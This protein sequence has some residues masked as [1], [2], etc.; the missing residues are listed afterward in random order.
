M[1]LANTSSRMCCH[2]WQT[3]IV[4]S[5]LFHKLAPASDLHR[6]ITARPLEGAITLATL[7]PIK[8][9]D[10]AILFGDGETPEVFTEPCGIVGRSRNFTVNT[11]SDDL[12][13]C[14]DPDL[15]A[16]DS[17]YKISVGESIDFQFIASA[18]LE[19]Q[20]TELAYEDGPTNIRYAINKGTRNGY[21]AGPAILTALSFSSERRGNVTGTGTLT[22]TSKPVWTPVTP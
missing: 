16:F 21:Y 4:T 9:G 11:Q 13:D 20:L 12:P 3:V 19:P 7:I 18:A 14:D 1:A 8:F 15:V 22:W 17:P 6:W 10:E 2:I 5:I